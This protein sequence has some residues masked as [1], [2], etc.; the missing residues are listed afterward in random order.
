[1]SYQLGC[2]SCQ[3]A[4]PGCLVSPSVIFAMSARLSWLARVLS[5]HRHRVGIGSWSE[6]GRSSRS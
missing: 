1:M 4:F 5:N 2:F 6:G 3:F